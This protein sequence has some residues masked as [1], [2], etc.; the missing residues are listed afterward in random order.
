MGSIQKYFTS[1]VCTFYFLSYAHCIKYSTMFNKSKSKVWDPDLFKPKFM[2][3]ACYPMLR[4]KTTIKDSKTN[5]F[6]FNCP[7]G[8]HLCC[9]QTVWLELDLGHNCSSQNTMKPF[10]EFKIFKPEKLL[11]CQWACLPMLFWKVFHVSE[12]NDSFW[13]ER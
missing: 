7:T 13:N 4:C 11:S 2:E 3:Q 5:L 1:F 8:W 6:L 10:A 12:E 9:K